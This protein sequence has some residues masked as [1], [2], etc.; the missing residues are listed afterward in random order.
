VPSGGDGS[1]I[2]GLAV[3]ITVHEPGH[4]IAAKSFG[5]RVE[6]FYGRLCRPRCGAPGARL[7]RHRHLPLGGLQI[8]G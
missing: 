3:L 8:S 1:S 5:M 4:F 6:K 2:L 7:V